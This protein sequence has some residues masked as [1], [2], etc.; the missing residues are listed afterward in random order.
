MMDKT[1]DSIVVGGGALGGWRCAF[2]LGPARPAGGAVVER[3]R[4][5]QGTTGSSFAWINGT[6]KWADG[7]YHRLNALGLAGYNDLA[8]EFGEEALGHRPDRLSER[9]AGRRRWPRRGAPTI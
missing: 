4:L 7:A 3:G 1:Y 6:S 8:R 2:F 9:G 5:A